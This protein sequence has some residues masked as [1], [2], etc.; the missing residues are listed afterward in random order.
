MSHARTTLE[1]V[2]SRE[3]RLVSGTRPQSNE[4]D[5]ELVAIELPA[6]R[7]GEILVRNLYMS[8][9]AYMRG[10]FG[11]AAQPLPGF[12]PGE[13]LEGA[14][15]GHIVASSATGFAPGDVVTSMRG[16]RE[17][18]VAHPSVVRRVDGRIQPLTAHL[19]VLGSTGLAAWAAFCL[20]EV[21]ARDNVFVSAAAGAVGNVI[22]QLAKLRGCYVAGAANSDQ[23]AAML[24]SELGFD[25]AF[26]GSQADLRQELD[27]AFPHGIDVYFENVGGAHL[28]VVMGAMRSGGRI[29]TC[30]ELTVFDQ[31]ALLK[32][33]RNRALFISKRLTMKGFLVSDWLALAPVFQKTISEHLLAGRLRAAETIIEGIER[34]PHA[35]GLLSRNESLGK[36]IVKLA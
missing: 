5:V 25:T 12:R 33:T 17:Y 9:D 29:V 19:S 20:A 22:G 26:N 7:T 34:A 15:V 16:W 3:I 28:K 1:P 27:V 24:V 6:L 23:A 30:G 8:V 32:R 14:A 11:N 36:I 21:S 13:A 18:F 10:R 2:I 31:P 35:F 4:I